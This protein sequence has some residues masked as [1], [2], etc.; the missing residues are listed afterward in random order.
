MLKLQFNFSAVNINFG[1]FF[2]VKVSSEAVHLTFLT[3]PKN[4]TCKYFL[5]I[6]EIQINYPLNLALDV[7]PLKVLIKI[8]SR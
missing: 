7:T 1:N 8:I 3:D 2:K 5:K 4:F 6:F